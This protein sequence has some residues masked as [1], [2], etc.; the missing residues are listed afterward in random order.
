[1]PRVLTLPAAGLLSLVALSLLP[2]SR[3]D[4]RVRFVGR[5]TRAYAENKF[6]DGKPKRETYVFAAG[7]RFEGATV[8]HTFDRTTVRNIAQ[9]LAPKLTKQNY[10]PVHD[11]ADAELLIVIHWGVTVSTHSLYE[12][13][14]NTNVGAD[15]AMTDGKPLDGASPD[16]TGVLGQLNY[17]ASLERYNQLTDRFYRESL[18]MNDRSTA[19]LLGY[20]PT[21]AKYSSSVRYAQEEFTLRQDLRDERYFVILRAYDLRNVSREA[22]SRPAWTLHLNVGSPGNNFS[23]A[24]N[25][26]A[27]A[28]ANAAGRNTGDVST[29]HPDVHDGA[30]TL[31][32]LIILGEE[33][34]G[35]PAGKGK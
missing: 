4:E 19:S 33:N 17:D 12:L 3:A 29:A 7:E 25:F 9:Y 16:I 11:I 26:M 6:V 28:A 31:G 13:T 27:Q 14:A 22:R 5:T 2:A 10:W 30:V 1:M 34:A 35:S 8:D 20:V 18:K 21:L 15:S 23:E 32:D 24:M